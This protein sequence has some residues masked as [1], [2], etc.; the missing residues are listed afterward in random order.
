MSH[1]PRSSGL[2]RF[3]KPAAATGT[4]GTALVVW[5]EEIMLYAEE[6]LA[7]IFLPVVAGVIYL[8]NAYVFKSRHPRR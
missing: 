8:F 2:H 4:G 7:L 3:W 5:F 1:S 6:I